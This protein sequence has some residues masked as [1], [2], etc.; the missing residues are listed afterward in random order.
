MN[1][2]IYCRISDDREGGGLGV[3]RQEADCRRHLTALGHTVGDVHT[4]NDLSAYRSKRRPGYEHLLERLKAGHASGFAVWHLDRLTRSPRELEDVID[5]VEATGALVLTVTGGAYD[6]TTTDGRAM[7]R[8]VA[9]FARKESEDKARRNRRKHLELAEAGRPV[10]GSRHFGY[11]PLSVDG[12]PV[13]LDGA[14]YPTLKIRESEAALIREAV[15]GVLA[16]ESL[17][18]IT[19]RWNELGVTLGRGGI[20]QA[21]AVT[22]ILRSPTIAGW[23]ALGGE[24]VTEGTWEPI[25]DLDTLRRVQAVL[26]E[27]RLL[28]GHGR[29]Q[30]RSYLLIGKVRCSRCGVTMVSQNHRG[31][32]RTYSCS[33][34]PSRRSCGGMRIVAPETEDEV[35]ERILAVLDDRRLAAAAPTRADPTAPL[36]AELGRLEVDEAQ[37]ATDYYADRVIDRRQF[38]AATEALTA[39]KADVNRRLAA[40][41]RIDAVTPVLISTEALRAEWP[42]M[43]LGRR[44]AVIDQVVETIVI[45]PAVRPYG[46]FQPDRIEVVW[47]A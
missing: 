9:T 31:R 38:F 17:R 15:A 47:R 19:R 43:E 25:I 24:L 29:A 30:P 27:R 21:Q 5:L 37:L 22:R 16:G 41:S 28:H 35:L 6:L 23:R 32:K 2:D 40:A 10:G 8:V 11:E 7:A 39:R 12:H 13:L 26:E 3:A 4:D 42:A 34:D 44:R 46:V 33:S 14:G 20:V 45:H 36:V 1:L 18:S